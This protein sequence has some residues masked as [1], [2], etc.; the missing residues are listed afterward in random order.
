MKV[1]S[2]FIL[3]QIA[4]KNVVLPIGMATVNF[5]GMMTLNNSGVMLWKT[6][7]QGATRDELVD[8]LT[9]EYDVSNE[10]AGKD[11]DEFIAALQQTGCIEE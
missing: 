1:K 3:R 11:V 4:G 7:E 2:D 9:K 10:E 5:D 8:V 6:L